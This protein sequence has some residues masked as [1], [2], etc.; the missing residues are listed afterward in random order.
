MNAI[1]KGIAG[2]QLAAASPPRQQFLSQSKDSVP[3]GDEGSQSSHKSPETAAERR[4]ARR[5]DP[6]VRTRPTP[7]KH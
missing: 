4:Q 2:S 3:K 6:H 1:H 5:D 7:I